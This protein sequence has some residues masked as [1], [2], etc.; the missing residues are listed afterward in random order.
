MK[1]PD[2][3]DNESNYAVSKGMIRDS[4]FL[5]MSRFSFWKWLFLEDLTC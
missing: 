4:C 1:S 3:P 5:D 2:K